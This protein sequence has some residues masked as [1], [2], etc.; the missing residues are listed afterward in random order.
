LHRA[1]KFAF[2]KLIKE[3]DF[4]DINTAFHDSLTGDTIKGVVVF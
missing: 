4:A 1:G 2:D 3:Y